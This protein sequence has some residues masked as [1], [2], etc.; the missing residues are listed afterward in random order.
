MAVRVVVCSVAAFLSTEHITTARRP[1]SII[2]DRAAALSCSVNLA[3]QPPWRRRRSESM[4]V[5]SLTCTQ[6]NKCPGGCCDL[7]PG[8]RC[9]CSTA[10]RR[11]SICRNASIHDTPARWFRRWWLLGCRV[12]AWRHL[13]CLY[14]RSERGGH[15]EMGTREGEGVTHMAQCRPSA[16]QPADSE[17]KRILSA[18]GTRRK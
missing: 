15:A 13:G 8:C 4:Q 10:N 14:S 11:G 17:Q 5:A 1:P 12:G 16:E 2:I 7:A 9:E 18:C 3:E 6:D